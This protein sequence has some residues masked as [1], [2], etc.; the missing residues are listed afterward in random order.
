MFKSA[1]LSSAVVVGIDGSQ[2]SVD[3]ALWAIDEAISREVPLR[4]V[5]VVEPRTHSAFDD[6]LAAR[7]T[8]CAEVSVRRTVAAVEATGRPVKVEWEVL[9]G[10]PI[11]ALLSA[12]R[13][14]ELLCIGSLGIAHAIGQRFGSTAAA[15]STAALCPVAIVRG[16]RRWSTEPQHVVVEVDESPNGIAVLEAAIAEARLRDAPLTVLTSGQPEPAGACLDKRLAQYRT[17]HPDID[18]HPVAVRGSTMNYVDRHADS[19][20][21]LVVGRHRGRG[22]GE[23][24]GS[25]QAVRGQLNCSVLVYPN[26]FHL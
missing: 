14:A 21:L 20:Q 18:F 17:S 4:L 3:A 6:E 12:A 13:S 24:G 5:Y 1:A 25:A 10:E 11:T 8:A 9:Q 15:M 19:I 23:L 26:H 7:D 2:R 22:I 16:G